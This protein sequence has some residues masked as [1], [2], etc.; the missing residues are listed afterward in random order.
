MKINLNSISF[1]ISLNSKDPIFGIFGAKKVFSKNSSSVTHN[2]IRVSITCQNSGKSN[3]P[4]PRKHPD[5]QQDRRRDT[6][7]FIDP[8]GY[9]QGSNKCNC[10]RLAFK[11]QRYRDHFR[12]FWPIS[13]EH[14]FSQIWDL[15]RDTGNN[16]NF[17]YRTNPVKINDQIFQ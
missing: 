2:F 8:S 4:I 11:S 12:T 6:D 10:S 13:Q 14:K 3:D 1:K 9:C 17:H 7:Y 16:I 15:C 5:R